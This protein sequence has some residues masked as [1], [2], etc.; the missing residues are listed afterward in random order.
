M[1]IRPSGRLTNS[2]RLGRYK[3]AHAWHTE[4]VSESDLAQPCAPQRRVKSLV[5]MG[6]GVRVPA[7]ASLSRGSR[8]KRAS[9]EALASR[10]RH[11]H[12]SRASDGVRSRVSKQLVVICRQLRRIDREAK[13]SPTQRAAQI[14][15]RVAHATTLRD[16][17]W[18]LGFKLFGPD[19]RTRRSGQMAAFGE[20]PLGSRGP[21]PEHD[22]A[23]G[24]GI[25]ARTGAAEETV[26]GRPRRVSRPPSVALPPRGQ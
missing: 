1:R 24:R 21:P 15:T 13:S 23:V 25:P 6:S 16:V 10:R 4:P 3:M 11:N 22:V 18:I 5:M 20:P 17:H 8:C 26:M 14:G 9:S 19:C 12:S 7:S 2:R